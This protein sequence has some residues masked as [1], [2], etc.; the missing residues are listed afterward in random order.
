MSTVSANVNN[1][2]INNLKDQL[3]KSKANLAEVESKLETA[4]KS[5]KTAEEKLKKMEND[6]K[7]EKLGL[8]KKSAELDIDLQVSNYLKYRNLLIKVDFI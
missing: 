7:K 1:K 2:E 3:N 5:K 4:N 6:F 8:E